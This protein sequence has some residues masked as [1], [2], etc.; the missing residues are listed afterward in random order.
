M[1]DEI[2]KSSV[3]K[4][5]TRDQV[6]S[7][8]PRYEPDEARERILDAAEALFR[9]LGYSKTTVGDVAQALTMSPANIYRFFPSKSAINDALCRRM[10]AEVHALC[11]RI[12]GAPGPAS[13]RLEEMI[14]SV[15][16]HNKTRLTE[17]QTVH[18]MVLVAMEEN[19]EA[20]EEHIAYMQSL[21]AGLIEEGVKAGEFVPCDAASVAE[22]LGLGCCGSFHPAMIACSPDEQSEQKVRGLARLL[23][24]GLRLPDVQPVAAASAE[25]AS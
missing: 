12:V 13:Q 3:I 5:Q 10:M 6:L 15:H 9:R 17:E 22:L 23:V 2:I 4:I 1:S 24:R 18:E 8:K 21:F 11:E 19:W 16:R 25:S 14:V 7:I 20:I